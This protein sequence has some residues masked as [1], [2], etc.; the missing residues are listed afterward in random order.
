MKNCAKTN[1]YVHRTQKDRA[2]K[3]RFRLSLGNTYVYARLR[4]STT[5]A[6]SSLARVVDQ[7]PW[8]PRRKG[9]REESVAKEGQGETSRGR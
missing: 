5:L 7:R 2:V 8:R 9:L 3:R 1:Q 6:R 4:I